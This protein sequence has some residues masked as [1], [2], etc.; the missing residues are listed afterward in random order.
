M[1]SG[2]FAYRRI[3]LR[4][5]HLQAPCNSD[6]LDDDGTKAVDARHWGR[7]WGPPFG[8]QAAD[9]R[10]LGCQRAAL[11]AAL[12]ARHRRPNNI[13]SSPTNFYIFIFNKN[14]N[15]WK[16]P[17]ASMS[18]IG[19]RLQDFTPQKMLK[20]NVELSKRGIALIM[21]MAR[22]P[23]SIKQM[24]RS[25]GLNSIKK[26]LLTAIVFKKERFT[27]KLLY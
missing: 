4:D 10:P 18:S 1:V 16:R 13:S 6:P 20:C 23:N 14:E 5:F 26:A 12:D 11:T 2:N 17:G 22:L 3:L 8:A 27:F 15:T 21:I 24:H 7:S 19:L 25:H 9:L